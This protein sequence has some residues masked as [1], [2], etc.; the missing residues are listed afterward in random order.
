VGP[1]PIVAEFVEC[2]GCVMTPADDSP[3]RPRRGVPS[4]RRPVDFWLR[5][6]DGLINEHFGKI[7]DEHGVTRRQWEVMNLLSTGSASHDELAEALAPFHHGLQ[8]RTLTDELAELEDSGWLLRREQVYELTE[9]GRTSYQRLE[10]VLRATDEE[11][12]RGISTEDYATMLDVLERMAINL[13]WQEGLQSGV[14]RGTM[15]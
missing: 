4:P 11:I 10:P 5:L 6:L 8:A 12:A 14:Q 3:S 15:K 1:V 13:G 7:L 2:E 9:R